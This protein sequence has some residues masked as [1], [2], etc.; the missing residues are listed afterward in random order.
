MKF[1]YET[2][3]TVFVLLVLCTLVGAILYMLGR[4]WGQCNSDVEYAQERVV[5]PTETVEATLFDAEVKSRR[6]HM[7]V[8]GH[9]RYEFGGEEHTAEVHERSSGLREEREATA[10]AL[11]EEGKTIE[12]EVQYN[13]DDYKDVSDSI[14]TEVP[15]CRPWIAGFFIFFCLIELLI[16]RGLSK[17]ILR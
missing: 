11:K 16:L 3:A 1:D 2:I 12:L 17:L 7:W 6:N 14:V 15:N 9:Y 4:F 13:P 10:R 5:W 8:V